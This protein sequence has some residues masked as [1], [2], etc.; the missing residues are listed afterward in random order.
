MRRARRRRAA[1]S[2]SCGRFVAPMTRNR[3]SGDDP[4]PS[5][6]TKNSVFRRRVASCSLS[7]RL[8][9]S[10]ST[11]SMKITDG[12]TSRATAKSARTSFSPSQRYL[13]V[14]ELA[15]MLKKRAPD[16]AASARA[17]MVLPFPGGPNSSS[18]REGARIPRNR[19]GRIMGR[20]T[21]SSSIDLTPSRPTTSVHFAA[22]FSST[23]S[24]KISSTHFRS[25]PRRK[26][27][28]DPPPAAAAGFGGAA[29]DEEE[30]CGR[31]CCCWDEEEEDDEEGCTAIL[32]TGAKD[33]VRLE[34]AEDESADGVEEQGTDGQADASRGSS[35]GARELVGARA[36]RNAGDEYADVS[37]SRTSRR[38]STRPT[39]S[40]TRP[41]SSS[42]SR[43]CSGE[44][45][46]A[47]WGAS[48]RA[49]AWSRSAS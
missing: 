7:E 28:E 46:A 38:A 47:D 49:A 43:C 10:E 4:R 45:R 29:A 24:A 26:L 5:N 33:G 15:L 18:P 19:S 2:G 31:C 36:A 23:S 6:W 20:M 14:S 13:D 9:R 27:E 42:S 12:C 17:I 44:V 40:A 41:A 16:S 48:D 25:T 8:E 39:W 21:I 1:S 32:E 37:A 22:G 3:S 11:S 35:T 30:D 34:D